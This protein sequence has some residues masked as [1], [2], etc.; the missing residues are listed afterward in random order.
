MQYKSSALSLNVRPHK[1]AEGAKW[2]V[3]NGDLYKEEDITFNDSWL[4]GSSNVALVDD[5]DEFSESLENLESIAA[6][7]DC[8]TDCQT[9]QTSSDNT[10][11]EDDWSEDEVEI[12][13]GVTD[14]MLTAPD[15]VTDNEQQYILHIAPG[16]GNMDL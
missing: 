6:D 16:E 9:Q 8:G 5:S 14:T 10:D 12:P 11:N 4:E 1:V 13:T 15:F 2:L 3:S 7:K